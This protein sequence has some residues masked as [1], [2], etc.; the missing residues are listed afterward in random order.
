M[1]IFGGVECSMC[2][3]K[4]KK[5]EFVFDAAT[6]QYYCCEEHKTKALQLSELVEEAHQKGMD[7]CSNCLKEIK[8][9]AYVC[10]YCGAVR[11]N[12]PGYTTGR[13]CPFALASVGKT[14][15]GVAEYTWKHQE[16][17][18]EYCAL[19]DFKADRCSFLSR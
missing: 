11:V 2:G 9:S 5:S 10:K 7:V 1:P 3:K 19:W 13:M 16:C 6:G 18:Q 4:G 15:M 8:P 14:E 12:F 17:I